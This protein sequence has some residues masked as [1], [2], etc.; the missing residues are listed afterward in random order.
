MHSARE[1]FQQATA[2]FVQGRHADA[3]PLLAEAVQAG[4]PEAQNLFGVMHLNALGMKQDTRRA[5]ELFSAAANAALKEAHYNLSNLLFNGIGIQ[6]DEVA[7]QRH[8]LE[9]ARAGHRPALRSLG[10]MYHLMGGSGDWARLATACFEQAA[11]AGDPISKYNLGLRYLHGHGVDVDLARASQWFAAAARDG[12]QRASLRLQA[13]QVPVAGHN[14]PPRALQDIPNLPGWTFAP[15]EMPPL[16]NNLSFLS[17]YGDV[18]DE[19]L[20]DHLIN[21]G[22]PQLVPAGVVDPVTGEQERSELRTS[23]STHFRPSMYDAV[24]A[25]IWARLSQIAGLPAE[26]AEPLVVM[27]YGP[28]QEYKQHRDYFV[29]VKNKVKRLVTVFVYLNDVEEGGDTAFTRLGVSVQPEQGKAV[30]FLNYHADGKP[31]PDTLHAGLPVIRG[32]KWLA[33]LWFWDRPF[34]WFA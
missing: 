17:E 30:K 23:Y 29:D 18:F 5:V 3:A 11:F 2:L 26:H 25:R 15:L 10:Y 31:N 27:R 14:V 9:A 33:T 13:L 16:L 7:G 12:M 20:C 34:M 19:Y 1:R 28:G 21:I 24:I 22:L 4:D 8:L 6:R 32:E